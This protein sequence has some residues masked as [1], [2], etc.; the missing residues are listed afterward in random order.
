MTETESATE[1][2]YK[3][4]DQR[5]IDIY[6]NDTI[7][8]YENDL[9]YKKFNNI[10][11]K[12][13]IGNNKNDQDSLEF[14]IKDCMTHG[15]LTLDLSHLNLSEFPIIP[16]TIHNK[17][18]YLFA[19]ENKIKIMKDINYLKNVI[20]VDLSNNNLTSLPILPENMEELL[21][22]DNSISDISS[23]ANYDFLKRLDCSNNCI[24]EM[25][26]I[27]SL[28]ILI[29]D[30]NVI[31]G[32]PKM[33]SLTQ[34]LCSHNV[35]TE[36]ANSS[37]FLEIIDCSDNKLNKIENFKNLKELYCSKNNI[38]HFKNLNKIEVIHC[39]KTMITLLPYIDTLK[40]LM[41]DHRENLLLSQNYTIL[42]SVIYKDKINMIN[43]K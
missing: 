21:I 11:P 26:I 17:M 41:C 4:R 8:I 20:V 18:K 3:L 12:R 2:A 37:E 16:S 34:L 28:N 1:Y 14:R 35:I 7:N 6:R 32:I 23:L 38:T 9:K 5:L 40:E 42:S 24:Q 19:S 29:C 13:V 31:E 10:D 33:R 36:I 30:Q 22:K 43:F 27:D 39:Y 15:S 25:P